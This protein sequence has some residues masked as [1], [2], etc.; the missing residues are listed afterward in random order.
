MPC[1]S[2]S[3]ECACHVCHIC[4]LTCFITCIARFFVHDPGGYVFTC[5]PSLSCFLP[6]S[7]IFF[8]GQP[9][10]TLDM[11][12]LLADDCGQRRHAGADYE[13]IASVSHHGKTPASGHYTADVKQP[14]GEW[15][16]FDDDFV[17]HV[18][19]S[20]VLR[21]DCV[22]YLLFYEMKPRT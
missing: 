1:T 16:R 8:C 21:R 5:L 9:Q 11:L 3:L 19:V 12:T 4:V 6:C 18:N 22:M 7:G 10:C 20:Q 14:D 15:L 2:L 17:S 13:L